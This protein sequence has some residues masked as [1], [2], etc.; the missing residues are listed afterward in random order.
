MCCLEG[1]LVPD[2]DLREQA[3]EITAIANEADV[4]QAR[5][6]ARLA[7]ILHKLG[8]TIAQPALAHHERP[9][10]GALKKAKAGLVEVQL[11]HR[12]AGGR[13]ADDVVE[14]LPNRCRLA[15]KLSKNR[16][17]PGPDSGPD[18]GPRIGTAHNAFV[19]RGRNPVPIS[20]PE[21]GTRTG[22]AP[23][24]FFTQNSGSFC[25]DLGKSSGREF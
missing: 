17:F 9:L 7:G 3:L 11:E 10:S 21:S 14:P 5:P 23:P 16:P 18:S 25:G 15:G 20:G 22:T 2:D 6:P 8:K 19:W 1:T 24:L 13:P 12:L 4:G